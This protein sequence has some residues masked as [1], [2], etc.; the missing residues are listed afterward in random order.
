MKP[1][2]AGSCTLTSVTGSGHVKYKRNYLACKIHENSACNL[3]D[4]ACNTHFHIDYKCTRYISY[5]LGWSKRYNVN[6]TILMQC[7]LVVLLEFYESAQCIHLFW[8]GTQINA[9]DSAMVR[10]KVARIFS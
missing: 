4:S 7:I 1:V 5:V 9:E 2:P 8:F 6:K 10:C 3:G